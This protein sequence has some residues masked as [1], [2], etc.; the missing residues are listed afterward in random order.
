MA[1]FVALKL[2]LEECMITADDSSDT[3]SDA[4]GSDSDDSDAGPPALDDPVERPE[5]LLESRVWGVW[6]AGKRVYPKTE[7]VAGKSFFSKKRR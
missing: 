1:D 7:N 5:R 4:G 2:P 3:K 6:V